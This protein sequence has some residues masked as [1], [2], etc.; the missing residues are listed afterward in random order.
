MPLGNWS[1]SSRVRRVKHRKRC[2]SEATAGDRPT[3]RVAKTG[4]SPKTVGWRRFRVCWYR[5]YPK[6]SGAVDSQDMDRVCTVEVLPVG[7]ECAG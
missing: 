1:V 4:R 3:M 7:S 6:L 5:A 2:T